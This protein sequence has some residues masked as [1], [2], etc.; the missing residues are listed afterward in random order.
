MALICPEECKIQEPVWDEIQ[1]ILAG[2]SPIKKVFPFDLKQSMQN[3]GGPACLRLRVV[4]NE[5]EKNAVHPGIWLTEK[6]ESELKNWV[7]ENYRDRLSFEDLADP[8]FLREV[9]QGFDRLEIILGMKI[10]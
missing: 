3:G 7:T 2:S 6:L 4:L 5:T 1:K 9:H 10:V 8:K